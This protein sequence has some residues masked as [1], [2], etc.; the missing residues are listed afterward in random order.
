MQEKLRIIHGVFRLNELHYTQDLIPFLKASNPIEF[1]AKF[2]NYIFEYVPKFHVPRLYDIMSEK[3]ETEDIEIKELY[4]ELK[5]I[6]IQITSHEERIQHNFLTLYNIC[7]LAFVPDDKQFLHHIP[8]HEV[9]RF[10][11]I[12]KFLIGLGGYLLYKFEI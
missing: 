11:R 6:D 5:K 7:V 4:D 10:R 12:Y 2:Y 8:L 3:E 1:Y 9:N